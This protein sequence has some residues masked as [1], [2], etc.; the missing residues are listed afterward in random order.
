[1]GQLGKPFSKTHFGRKSIGGKSLML[2]SKRWFIHINN[3]ANNNDNNNIRAS[4]RKADLL[5]FSKSL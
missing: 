3:V 1:M 4:W 2:Y 5:L